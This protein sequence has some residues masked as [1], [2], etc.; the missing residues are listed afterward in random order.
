MADGGLTSQQV[1]SIALNVVR[2][3]LDPLWHEVEIIRSK[4]Q[5]VETSIQRLDNKMQSIEAEMNKISDSIFQMTATL[6]RQ[7]Q[8]L[9]DQTDRQVAA[10]TAGLALAT[11]ATAEV[12]A[13]VTR[14]TTALVEIEFLR[15]YN[16]ARGPLRV[17]ERFIDE[18]EERFSKAIE[19]VH[20]NRELYN[21]HFGR[22][23]SEHTEKVHV[24][25]SHI[26]DLLESDFREVVEHTLKVP[27]ANFAQLA[28][29]VDER[30]TEARTEQLDSALQKLE[31]LS[32]EPLVNAGKSVLSTLQNGWVIPASA[33]MLTAGTEV[34]LSYAV[35]AGH[36]GRLLDVSRHEEV[37]VPNNGPLRF[38]LLSEMPAPG[39]AEDIETRLRKKEVVVRPMASDKLQRIKEEIRCLAVDGLLDEALI[40]GYFA[41]LDVHGLNE[42]VTDSPGGTQ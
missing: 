5:N 35:C 33:Q 18:I 13:G 29:A 41:L 31:D 27:R 8:T 15:L 2:A 7:L 19:S 28:L 38:R 32:L 11:A 37:R 3:E 9:S 24:I 22:I 42:L 12:E 36:D 25:G 1:Q 20:L 39:L 6:S 23:E 17:V 4:M 16:D 26:F 40:A 34:V 10:T 14:N 21:E 30:R